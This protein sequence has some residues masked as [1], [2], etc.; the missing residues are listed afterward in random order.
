MKLTAAITA[1][2][3]TATPAL[4][5]SNCGPKEII[6]TKLSEK[7]G[8]TPVFEGFNKAKKV[9]V[10]LWVNKETG[11]WSATATYATGISC[12]VDGGNYGFMLSPPIPGDPA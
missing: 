10:T 1:L 4:A 3:M 6:E 8:E 2:I 9:I 12:L 11:S 5:Q 7:Y